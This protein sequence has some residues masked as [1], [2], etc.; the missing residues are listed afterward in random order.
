MGV[1]ARIMARAI[2]WGGNPAARVINR[3]SYLIGRA[4]TTIAPHRYDLGKTRQEI[5]DILQNQELETSS[6]YRMKLALRWHWN[7]PYKDPR[8]NIVFTEGEYEG[9]KFRALYMGRAGRFMDKFQPPHLLPF[10]IEESLH[11]LPVNKN[12]KA[13]VRN[14]LRRAIETGWH[15]SNIFGIYNVLKVI[16]LKR[17]SMEKSLTG[18]SE[19]PMF[20]MMA[21]RILKIGSEARKKGCDRDAIDRLFLDLAALIEKLPEGTLTDD[22]TFDIVIDHITKA[23]ERYLHNTLTFSYALSSSLL[24]IFIKKLPKH[25]SSDYERFNC[26]MDICERHINKMGSIGI[27]HEYLLAFGALLNKVPEEASSDT[28]SLENYGSVFERMLDKSIEKKLSID[29]TSRMFTPFRRLIE[30]LPGRSLVDPKFLDEHAAFLLELGRAD[31]KPENIF[32]VAGRLTLLMPAD[33]AVDTRKLRDFIRIGCQTFRK[34]DKHFFNGLFYAL[35]RV[36]N[37]LDANYPDYMQPLDEYGAILAEAGNKAKTKYPNVREMYIAMGDLID[38]LPKE[39]IEDK[40]LLKDILAPG[41]KAAERDDVE[42]AAKVYRMEKHSIQISPNEFLSN[43]EILR[44]IADVWNGLLNSTSKLHGRDFDEFNAFLSTL[45]RILALEPGGLDKLDKYKCLVLDNEST[46]TD[47]S[48]SKGRVYLSASLHALI[49]RLPADRV[50][51]IEILKAYREPLLLAMEKIREANRQYGK[52]DDFRHHFGA[53]IP[54]AITSMPEEVILDSGKFAQYMREISDAGAEIVKIRSYGDGSHDEFS[55]NMSALC[56]QVNHS[57]ALLP[58]QVKTDMTTLKWFLQT[59]SVVVNRGT[60]YYP[61]TGDIFVCLAA[62]M[63]RLPREQLADM[64]RLNG[65]RDFLINLSDT[66]KTY[67]RN[68]A[69]ANSFYE[70]LATFIDLLT[71]DAF[72]G[73]RMPGFISCSTAKEYEMLVDILICNSLLVNK[74]KCS[75][76]IE[77]IHLD[78]SVMKEKLVNI[79]KGVNLTPE[80]LSLVGD[81]PDGFLKEA[82]MTEKVIALARE[83]IPNLPKGQE[84]SNEAALTLS[85]AKLAAH[86]PRIREDA[87]IRYLLDILNA[88]GSI[89]GYYRK[90]KAEILREMETAGFDIDYLLSGDEVLSRDLSNEAINDQV[91]HWKDNL[92]KLMRRIVGTR[93]SKPEK[94]FAF[95]RKPTALLFKLNHVEFRKALAGDKDAAKKIIEA[96]LKMIESQ[97]RTSHDRLLEEWHDTL[98]GIFGLIEYEQRNVAVSGMR[99]LR[100][101]K[102]F[103]EILFDNERLGCCIFWPHGAAMHEIGRIL[104]DPKTP[105]LEIWLEGSNEFMGIVPQYPGRNA[106]G[107]PVLF[108]DTVEYSHAIY[109]AVGR[110]F[111]LKFML[112]AL[113]LDAHR[114]GAKEMAVYKRPYGTSAEFVSFVADL[115]PRLNGVIADVPEYYFQAVDAEDAGLADSKSGKHHYTDAYGDPAT[116]K[117]EKECFVINVQSYIEKVL[118]GKT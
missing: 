99:A 59:A 112:D 75:V 9:S 78:R 34:C 39:A 3:S 74:F 76:S 1:S 28:K 47:N 43:K 15:K 109:K 86:W 7:T 95:N 49:Q 97:L 83:I 2:I 91:L 106:A 20:F 105:L 21:D 102:L 60:R 117:G 80:N 50:R 107:Q 55:A 113:V 44:R 87:N 100:S 93:E 77:A 53:F 17:A 11:L 84:S 108:V 37:K 33:W 69:W 101:R 31:E 12:I 98:S 115:A 36:L 72:T 35:G 24:G 51:D 70:M 118:K 52:N 29:A 61:Y 79:L 67:R 22:K 5:S 111:S 38:V 73:D 85:M 25:I 14:I 62:I 81:I 4:A 65:Y 48:K 6:G 110:N 18:V 26:V 116:L 90:T 58:D 54:E 103:P 64:E 16:L 89:T 96:L 94:I 57:L 88:H 40:D 27:A 30:K 82:N 68:N 63:K 23:G 10:K 104:L 46:A 71:P 92:M 41:V 13:A 56:P 8:S 114:M 19:N 45:I 66:I 32:S 42:L